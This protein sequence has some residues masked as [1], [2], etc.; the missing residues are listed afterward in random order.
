[1][2]AVA[3]YT[4][5]QMA[6]IKRTVAKDCTDDEFRLFIHLCRAT[7][8]DPLR[9]QAFAF[10][11]GK[12]DKDQSKRQLTLVTSIAG[13]RTI[14]E[15]TGNYR[16]DNEAPRYEYGEKD[17]LTNPLGIERCEVT[18]YKFSHS[19]WHPV[20]GEAWW[21]EHVP[22]KE[23]W[24]DQ[25]HC[26]NGIFQIDPKKTGWVKMPRLMI[27]KIAE[28]SALRKAWP[29]DFSDTLAEEEIDREAS[30]IDAVEAISQA[31]EQERLNRIGRLGRT[32]MI[33]LGG[34]VIEPVPVGQF[35]DRCLAFIEA[36]KERPV[37]LDAWR[38]RNRHSLREFH[39]MEKAEAFE[40]KKR[41]DEALEAAQAKIEATAAQET[42]PAA[43]QVAASAE[44]VASILQDVAPEE[45]AD[46]V[47]EQIA[48]CKSIDELKAWYDKN[49]QGFDILSKER[50][51]VLRSAYRK[52]VDALR[53]AVTQEE[54]GAQ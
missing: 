32:I 54:T 43:S 35:T 39:A 17:P 38:T 24:D 48:A 3:E 14:A 53:S 30:R 51:A 36:N 37:E 12:N 44:E 46:G 47:L 6:L 8:L 4:G 18:V 34:N 11:F 21:S 23:G 33:D 9:K 45:M 5:G 13:Y 1:M 31:E 26:K 29:D 15:R 41:L 50:L 28:A 25:S 7:R 22:L 2:T 10:C 42:A 19:E 40:I 49:A 16:P 20:I 52:R 27:A